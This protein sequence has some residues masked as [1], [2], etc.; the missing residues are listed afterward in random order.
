MLGDCSA[1][2]MDLFE[3]EFFWH[4]RGAFACATERQL[5]LIE[6]TD[7]STLFLDE[8]GELS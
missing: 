6:Y 7:G 8:I 3:R 1:V 2:P 4:E 5:G